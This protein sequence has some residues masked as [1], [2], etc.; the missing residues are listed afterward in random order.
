MSTRQWSP[1]IMR[2][3]RGRICVAHDF[4]FPADERVLDAGDVDDA[5]ALEDHGVLD[6]GVDDLAV[7]GRST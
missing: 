3:A 1:T 4:D 7:G 5:A 2:R 6:L